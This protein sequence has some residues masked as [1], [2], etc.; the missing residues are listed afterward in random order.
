MH[1]CNCRQCTKVID[2]GQLSRHLFEVGDLVATRRRYTADTCDAIEITGILDGEGDD[3]TY[4]VIFPTKRHGQAKRKG[5]RKQRNLLLV[6]SPED[7]KNN[8]CPEIPYVLVQYGIKKPHY[9]SFMVCPLCR[10]VHMHGADESGGGGHRVEHCGGA[11]LGGKDKRPGGYILA[12]PPIRK[13][14]ARYEEDPKDW[15]LM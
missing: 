11:F 12:E 2:V 6:L 7:E 13:Y 14:S 9:Q 10:E 4:E 8:D 15:V 5:T 1:K 3:T